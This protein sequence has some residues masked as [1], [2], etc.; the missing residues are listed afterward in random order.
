MFKALAIAATFTT[1]L[2]Q[3]P[4]GNHW[5]GISPDDSCVRIGV[6]KIYPLQRFA[7]GRLCYYLN[8]Y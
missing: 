3:G 7:D 4:G 6:K 8:S 1:T 5:Y 2:A